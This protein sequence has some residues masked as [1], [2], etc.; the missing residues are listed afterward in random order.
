MDKYTAT[1]ISML[2]YEELRETVLIDIVSEQNEKLKELSSLVSNICRYS[3]INGDVDPITEAGLPEPVF[4][5]SIAH[6]L[7]TIDN[8]DDEIEKLQ[9]EIRSLNSQ[10]DS[11]VNVR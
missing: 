1:E 5:K 8:K 4:V 2:T 7:D 10:L 11:I 3:G 6:L 9:N